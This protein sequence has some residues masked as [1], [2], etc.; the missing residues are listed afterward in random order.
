MLDKIK[1]LYFL[2]ELQFTCFGQILFK[3]FEFQMVSDILGHSVSN[4]RPGATIWWETETVYFDCV[5]N[6]G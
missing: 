3:L 4:G 5:L 1:R 2:S 6:Q